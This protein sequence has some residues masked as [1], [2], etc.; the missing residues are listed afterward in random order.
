MTFLYIAL[1]VIGGVIG[2]YY[3]IRHTTIA[4][5]NADIKRFTL[6]VARQRVQIHK[7]RRERNQFA[8][9][10]I[11]LRNFKN[12]FNALLESTRRKNDHET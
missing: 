4:L 6:Q 10:L 1:C 12:R 7:M 9:E 3:G 11:K 2:G 8:L 5:L